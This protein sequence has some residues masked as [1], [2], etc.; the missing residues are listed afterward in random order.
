MIRLEDSQEKFYFCRT[1]NWSGV[2]LAVGMEQAAKLALA[3]ATDF[4][5][6]DLLVSPAILVR[7]IVDEFFGEEDE[8][9]STAKVY[10][11]MGCHKE[12]NVIRNFI[13]L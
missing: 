3:E 1:A 7:E 8:V 5:G 10:A 13:K 11:D 2:V 9:F 6:E 12:A 4:S